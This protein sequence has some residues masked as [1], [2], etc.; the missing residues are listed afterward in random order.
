M[1]IVQHFFLFPTSRRNTKY[2]F[3]IE[4]YSKYSVYKIL[5][6]FVYSL[7][8][9]LENSLLRILIC[10]HCSFCKIIRFVSME[11]QHKSNFIKKISIII[12]NLPQMVCKAKSVIYGR[13]STGFSLVFFNLST[14]ISLCSTKMLQNCFKI[15]KWKAGVKIF[16]RLCH[17]SPKIM[18]NFINK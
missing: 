17:F 1:Q 5:S 6:H 14:I 3:R 4:P 13:M 2:I 11:L 16:L 9:F 7:F 18:T 15:L 12:F 10:P 8:V